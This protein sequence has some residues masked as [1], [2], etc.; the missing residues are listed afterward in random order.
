MRV[1]VWLLLVLFLASC[2]ASGCGAGKDTP[3]SQ[4]TPLPSKSELSNVPKREPHKR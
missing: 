3:P 2:L 4:T 1:T